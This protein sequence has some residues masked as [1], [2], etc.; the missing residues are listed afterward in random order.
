MPFAALERPSLGLSLLKA[1]LARRGFPCDVRY[2][3]FD[4]AGF[5]GLEDYLWIHGG[6]P[7]TAFAGDWSFTRSLYGDRPAADAQYV[8]HVLLKTWGLDE[9]AVA[10]IMRIRSY[11]EHFLDH[12]M[13][14]IAWG[15]YK[16]VGF[17]STFEQNVASLAL[18]RRIKEQ[19]PDMTIVFGGANWED[20][21]GRALHR[22][23]PFVDIV[24]SGEADRS[25]VEL[26]ERLVEGRE[27]SDVHGIV[28]RREGATLAT[29]PAELVGDLDALP[30]PDF[31]GFFQDRAAS[32]VAADVTPILLLETSRGCWWG[33][34]HHCTFCGLNGGTMAFRSKSAERVIEEIRLLRSKHGVESLSVVD[35]IL[36]MRYFQTL[37]PRIAE[38]RLGMSLFYEVKANL[39]LAQ[40]RQLA[41]AGV[42][43][44]QPGLESL[45]D[46]VLDLM[47]K[48]TTA[49]QNIQLLKWCREFGVKPEWNLLYGFP[50][51]EPSDYL[52]MIPLID[53]IPHLDPPAAYGPVRLDRFSPYHADP[54]AYDM[55]NIRPLNPYGYLYP[56][57]R[58]T[59]MRIAYYFDY[60]YRDGRDPATYVGPVLER[61]RGW[62]G[63]GAKGGLWVVPD[64]GERITIVENRPGH[65]RETIRLEGWRASLY[66]A[67]DRAH[68]LH[69]LLETTRRQGVADEEATDFLERCVEHRLMVNVKER[70]LAVAVHSPPRTDDEEDGGRRP[71]MAIADATAGQG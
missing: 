33:A 16:I 70:Y 7:Y 66:L 64:G 67:C 29:G 21:M 55:V 43:Q 59:L 58:D 2:L 48:G 26:L 52:D 27:P 37:L 62:Q 45:S 68:N 54:E 17:T 19:R 69:R 13:R 5:V 31:D 4:F 53:A 3:A 30:I 46:H 11:S 20:E 71:S 34:K 1:Q 25:F 41:R 50:G 42:R 24:C 18:A 61:V 6:L 65:S 38:E 14:S 22:S 40:V 32:P 8:E 36:D 63:G 51:E 44:V 23:F 15:N 39:S 28:Y 60:D 9:A 35:N 57:D 56:F 49:L 47:D 12:C 10:R